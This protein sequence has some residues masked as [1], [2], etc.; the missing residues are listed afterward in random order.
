MTRLPFPTDFY[1]AANVAF[2][3]HLRLSLTRERPDGPA[4]VTL[5]PRTELTEPGGAQSPA[6]IFTVAEVAAA[7]RAADLVWEHDPEML[8]SLVLLTTKAR[9]RCDD[10]V[11]GAVHGHASAGG[12][13]S[14]ISAGLDRTRKTSV[15]VV[16]EV[17]DD[18]GAGVG[19]ATFDIYLRRMS[20]ENL[21]AMVPAGSMTPRRPDGTSLSAR[22]PR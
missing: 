1:G 11:C 3:R 15:Q 19:Q 13:A 6:A 18:E 14:A 21:E 9:F 20:R 8:P 22:S 10:H 7:I 17:L 12:D 4:K 2:Q 16:V 5:A